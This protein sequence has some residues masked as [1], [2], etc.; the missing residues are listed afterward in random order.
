MDQEV[1]EAPTTLRDTLESSFELAEQG[2]LPAV[3]ETTT[4]P[5]TDRIRDE[6]GKFAKPERAA[7][8]SPVATKHD[9]PDPVDHSEQDAP[10]QRPTTWKKDYLPLWDK[11]QAGQPLTQEEA[12]KFLRY[13][14]QR[15]NEYKTGVSTYKGEAENARALQE[16]IAPFVPDLQRNGIHPQRGLTT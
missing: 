15:E 1:V 9:I 7:N 6:A 5:T 11:L 10:L 14:N 8:P 3:V 16:A 13:A 2:N 12:T 4:L